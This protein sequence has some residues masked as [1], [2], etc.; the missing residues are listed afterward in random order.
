MGAEC[1][2]GILGLVAMSLEEKEEALF[3]E[4]LAVIFNLI[5]RHIVMELVQLLAF[6]FVVH[7]LPEVKET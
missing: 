6:I 2:E 7:D 3:V 5:L 1:L 4:E